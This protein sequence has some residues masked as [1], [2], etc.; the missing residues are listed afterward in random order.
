MCETAQASSKA[1][2]SLI[3]AIHTYFSV[4]LAK[5][6]QTTEELAL[7]CIK[8][9]NSSSQGFIRVTVVSLNKLSLATL[10]VEE[11]VVLK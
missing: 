3:S 6:H 7:S 4:C 1:P 5:V 2:A 8:M 11:P 10:M 9:T